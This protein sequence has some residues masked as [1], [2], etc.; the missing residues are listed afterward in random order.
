[1]KRTLLTVVLLALALLTPTGAAL[2]APGDTSVLW[3]E[4]VRLDASIVEAHDQARADVRRG[5]NYSALQ[6]YQSVVAETGKVCALLEA[7]YEREHDLD[8]QMDALTRLGVTRDLLSRA[9]DM[10]DVLRRT[11]RS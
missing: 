3:D 5:L 7:L 10:V 9:R 8:R 1:M 2:A 11:G 4:V 6:R